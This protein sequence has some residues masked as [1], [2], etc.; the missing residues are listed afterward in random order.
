MSK[1]E[2]GEW[3]NSGMNSKELKRRIARRENALSSSKCV[4]SCLVVEYPA[5]V[6]YD[7]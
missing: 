1:K 2:T 5:E 3:E 7:T 4:A 6:R